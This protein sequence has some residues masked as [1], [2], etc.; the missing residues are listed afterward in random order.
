MGMGREV[1]FIQN[2]GSWDLGIKNECAE[3]EGV[4]GGEWDERDVIGIRET[5]SVERGVLL[6]GLTP[7]CG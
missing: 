6:S 4:R 1:Q 7:E 5:R 3:A 2:S